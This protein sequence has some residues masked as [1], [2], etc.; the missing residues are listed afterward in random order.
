MRIWNSSFFLEQLLFFI[1]HY[2]AH[3][4]PLI[5][6]YQVINRKNNTK[7]KQLQEQKARK[8]KTVVVVVKKI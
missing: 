4:K 1:S 5:S 2:E 7:Q 3:S 6:I 8:N